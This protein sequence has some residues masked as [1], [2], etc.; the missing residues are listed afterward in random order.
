MLTINSFRSFF[1]IALIVLVSSFATACVN[2]YVDNGTKEISTSQFKKPVSTSDTQL[3]FEFRTK[4]AKNDRATN[5]LN[6]QIV[7]QVKSSGLFSNV[8][9]A[10]VPSGAILSIVLDNIPLTD[11]A[12]SKGFLTGFTFG[13]AGS[14]VSDGYV[15]TAKY[16]PPANGK[17][18]STEAKHVIHTTIGNASTPVNATKAESIIIAVRTMTRQIVSNVLNNLSLDNDFK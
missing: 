6:E 4:G 15:C 11:D 1:R 9:V 12:A 13:L 8:S 7:E 10:P 2:M 14:Q 3:I 18:I 17:S 5:L 16:L